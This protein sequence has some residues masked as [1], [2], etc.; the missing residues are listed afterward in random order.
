MALTYCACVDAQTYVIDGFINGYGKCS[1][2]YNT[3]LFLFSNRMLVIRAGIHDILTR[4]ANREDP[5]QTAYSDM[6]LPSL[7]KSFWQTT[8]V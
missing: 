6:S 8:R 7:S 1:K 4:I 3:F 5:D 2:I